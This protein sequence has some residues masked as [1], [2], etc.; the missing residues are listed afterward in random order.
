M[1]IKEEVKYKQNRVRKFLEERKFSA[2]YIKK[3][4][5]F[6]WLTGGGIN[7]VNV[8]TEIG[9][10]GLLL[11][12]DKAYAVCN[13][14]EA[15]RMETEEAL[16]EQGYE[17]RRFPWHDDREVSIVR[18]LGGSNLAADFGF[19]GAT[20][21]SSSLAPLRYSLTSWE[22]ERY[23]EL[24]LLTSQMAEETLKT[25]KRG[26]KECSI[27]GRLCERL[28]DHRIDYVIAFCAADDRIHSYRHPIATERKIENRAMLSVNSRKG[29]LIVSITRFVQLGK[30][31]ESLKKQY[32]DNLYI[33]SI[34]MA[35]TIPGRPV[36]EAFKAG[37]EAYKTLGYPNEWELHH[38]GGAIGYA[39]REYRVT[40][41]TPDIVQEN[42][43]FTWNPSISGTKSE[44]TMLATKNGPIV[45]SEPVVYPALIMEA[46]GFSFRRPDILEL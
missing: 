13:N 14:I 16:P 3:E 21:V 29:G 5:N 30:V 44:D 28:W 24:A 1:F 22:V 11:T 45:L 40:F 19:P 12:P 18:E 10:V 31:P 20:D 8:A 35:G 42:Q 23:K 37:L 33:D 15:V 32:R 4:A 43:G 27:I 34:F 9:G 41:N 7:Y 39:P 25:V 46:G 26:D 17:I 6:S 38:Q 36:V 2:L